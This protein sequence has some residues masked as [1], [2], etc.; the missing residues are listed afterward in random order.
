MYRPTSRLSIVVAFTLLLGTLSPPAR[1][2]VGEAFGFGARN[3]ALAGAGAAWGFDGYAAY[4]NPAALA[5][6]TDKRL[7]FSYGFLVMQPDFYSI[8][9]VVT[10]NNYTSDASPATYGSV[11]TSYKA[12][13]GTALGLGLRLFPEFFNLSAGVTVFLPVN[14]ISYIDTGEVYQPEYVLYRARTQRPQIEIGTGADLGKHFFFG[15]GVHIGYGL[16]GNTTVFLNTDQTKISTMRFAATLKPKAS[17]YLGILLASSNSTLRGPTSDPDSPGAWTLGAVVRFANNSPADIT[18]NTAT[19]TFGSSLPAFDF[20]FE[21][22]AALYYDPF[23]A[24]LGWSM[25]TS[26]FNRIFLQLEYQ[27]WSDYQ[28]S[29]VTIQGPQTDKCSGSSCG[30]AIAGSNNPS[31]TFRDIVVPRVGNEFELNRSTALR[32][33]YTYHMS[34]FRDLPAGAGNYLDPPRHSFSAGVGFKFRHFIGFDTP[35]NVD[36]YA[37]YE[38]LVTQTISKSPGDE[39]GA[40]G[41]SKIGSP[42]YDAGGKIYGG[43]IS[44]T[45]AF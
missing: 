45:L 6:L 28:S 2:N 8:D 19:R 30:L 1:A 40:A 43:G 26:P 24:E 36:I 5:L 4:S 44:L 42:G 17:P 16:T 39:T 32:V 25:Q 29:A 21:A 35:N 3:E 33:G 11:D 27:R 41:D 12:T 9:H 18:V 37:S 14:Q 22:L 31:Y 10:N 34:I 15:A 13:M 7:V 23:T 38:R 20:H